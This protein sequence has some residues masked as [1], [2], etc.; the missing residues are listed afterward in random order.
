MIATPST[1]PLRSAGD[2]FWYRVG[3]FPPIL[4]RLLARHRRGLPLTD[5][6]IAAK[7]GHALTA[8]Q[9][10]CLSQLR[11]W[12]NVSVAHLRAFTRGCDIDFHDPVAMHRVKNY[13][14]TTR[15]FEYLKRS[16]QW[17]TVFKPLL[18]QLTIQNP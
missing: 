2:H 3:H 14:R 15:R 17:E 16:P 5:A 11:S 6:E 8:Y 12:E 1:P 7:A 18:R 9:V 13:L 4:C 10:H